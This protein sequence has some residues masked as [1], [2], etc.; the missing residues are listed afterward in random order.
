MSIEKIWLNNT[1][2]FINRKIE[3]SNLEELSLQINNLKSHE[4][5]I[6]NYS[7]WEECI[8]DLILLRWSWLNTVA[9]FNFKDSYIDEKVESILNLFENIKKKKFL[10]Q[11]SLIKF[12]TI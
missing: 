10:I 11:H 12:C 7:I 6:S 1:P 8:E 3:Y 2:E 9:P 5:V 4:E